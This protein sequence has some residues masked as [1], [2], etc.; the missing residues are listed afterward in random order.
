[1]EALID[2]ECGEGYKLQGWQ[3][4]YLLMIIMRWGEIGS[5]KL[6]D[7]PRIKGTGGPL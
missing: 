7:W 6:R 1:M 5:Q 4:D 3:I 2:G